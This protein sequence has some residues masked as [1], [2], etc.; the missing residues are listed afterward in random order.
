MNGIEI[1]STGYAKIEKT[2]NNA[3][4]ERMVETN[5]SSHVQEFKEDI[6]LLDPVLCLLSKQLKR[7]H[8]I[9]I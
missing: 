8:K 9:K 2:L 5:G 6:F 1:I 7:Q 3:Q 4:L